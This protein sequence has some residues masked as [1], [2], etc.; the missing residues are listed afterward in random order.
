MQQDNNPKPAEPTAPTPGP[1]PELDDA[2]RKA[3]EA[4]DKAEAANDRL[5]QAGHEGD[6]AKTDS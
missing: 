1:D 6:P 5:K 4:L 2:A 3:R